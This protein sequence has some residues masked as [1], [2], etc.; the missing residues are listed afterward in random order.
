MRFSEKYG[1]KP[2]S[3]I[4]QVESISAELRN[5]LW[6]LLKIFVWD[7]VYYSQHEGGRVLTQNANP[8]MRLF[9]NELWFH[10]FK[11]PLD[12]LS[13]RFNEVLVE[14]RDYFF[15]CQ[16]YE[17]YDFVQFVVQ[18]YPYKT[19]DDFVQACNNSLEREMSGFRLV[20]T[21]ITP[22]TDQE[23]IGAI[24]EALAGGNSPVRAH[25]NRA[26]E[27]LSDRTS[28]DYRNSIK[29]SISAV[30]SLVEAT[31]GK[32]GTLGTLIKKMEDEIGLHGALLNAF[33]NL[34]GTLQM[35][36]EYVMR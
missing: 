25:L 36:T 10:H 26:L 23:E 20:G 3:A 35:L 34:Y 18:N 17:V 2:V 13:L 14:L 28:P 9:T 33:S 21:E 6:S 27:L 4:I 8:E 30:E 22:I 1:Y 15:R 32:K 12:T 16:W 7:K 29:E 31:L 24:E 5:S 11:R 19:R